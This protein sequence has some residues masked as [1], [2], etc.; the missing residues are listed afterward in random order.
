[1]AFDWGFNFR[2]NLAYATDPAGTLFV[3]HYPGET[4][5][6][7]DYPETVSGVTFGWVDYVAVRTRDRDP[8]GNDGRLAGGHRID[9]GDSPHKFRVDLP[10]P[11]RY[12]ISV[13]IGDQFYTRT[14]ANWRILDNTTELDSLGPLATSAPNAFLD[15]TGTNHTTAANWVSNETPVEYTFA[16][17]VF[18]FEMGTST[19]YPYIAH[20]HIEEIPDADPVESLQHDAFQIGAY[21]QPQPTPGGTAFQ[22]G[23]SNAFQGPA[24]V[25]DADEPT[26]AFQ[27][28]A[29]QTDAFQIYGTDSPVGGG[30]VDEPTTPPHGKSEQRRR[31]RYDEAELAALLQAQIVQEDAEI[32][33]VI[34]VF[35]EQ[36]TVYRMAA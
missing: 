16:T 23:Q 8:G 35:L 2:A 24:G 13:A 11:G 36:G 5:W 34:E 28:D 6:G 29:F 20:I 26:T 14:D 30:A 31:V 7:I 10:N 17:S 19:D 1:L 3:D 12:L 33:K 22:I 32:L 4:E 25:R 15:A 9:A 27:Q 21:D 18:I